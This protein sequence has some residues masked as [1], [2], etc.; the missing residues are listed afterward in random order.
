MALILADS[1]IDVVK[2]LTSQDSHYTLV[3]HPQSIVILT[4][5]K[6]RKILRRVRFDF[7]DLSTLELIELATRREYVAG[8]Q[9]SYGVYN[10]IHQ[11]S[12]PATGKPTELEHR[13][14]II[15]M[16]RLD[17]ALSLRSLV[18]AQSPNLADYASPLAARLNRLHTSA[19][20]RSWNRPLAARLMEYWTKQVED[21]DWLYAL[22]QFG[23]DSAWVASAG[24]KLLVR[25]IPFINQREQAEA[26]RELHGDPRPEHIFFEKEEIQ[27]IDPFVLD[28]GRRIADVLSDLGF[29]SSD[30]MALGATVLARQIESAYFELTPWK[31][32]FHEVLRF[33]TFQKAA[34]MSYNC[35]LR[36][37]G[38]PESKPAA[39]RA[40]HQYISI[41]G[42]ILQEG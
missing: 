32:G 10:G 33:F 28:E 21:T 24:S 36:S 42:P 3:L 11:I 7:A 5:E 13:A 35:W 18:E 25:T 27:L 20:A 26:V 15:D 12:L 39:S 2:L 30:L 8:Q 9:Y 17:E 29:L 14:F 19:P 1:E 31:D 38:D 40:M 6:A 37:I 22:K 16:R 4:Q 41:F 34:I 23:I